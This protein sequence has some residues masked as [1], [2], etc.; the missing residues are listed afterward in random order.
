MPPR[1]FAPE[2]RGPGQPVG[3]PE[4]EAHH[5]AHVLRLTVGAAVSVF[6][7]RGLECRGRVE[8][9]TGSRVVVRAGERIASAPEP[10]VRLCV[11]HALL[12]GRT[13][14]AVV[15]DVTMVGAAEI[16]PLL[17]ERTEARPRDVERWSR[18][19]V[20]SAKQCRRAVVPVVQRPARLE[21]LLE[22]DPS[23]VRLLL[24]EPEADRAAPG[25]LAGLA[26]VPPPDAATIVVGP[27]GGWS[28]GEV[29]A[30]T[31]AGCLPI[32]LGRRTWR[33]DAAAVCAIAV[34]QFIWGDL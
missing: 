8:S 28:A 25:A 19:A 5:L 11:A 30:A 23:P 21:V 31:A 27:E 14:D 32:T 15:R 3:L 33:A 18:I 22:G 26:D 12:K 6:D 34:L 1:F 17:T 29:R 20:A 2:L 7:G 13:L 24:V 4:E 9:V 16:Q 10:R